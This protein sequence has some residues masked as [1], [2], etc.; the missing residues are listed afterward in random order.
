MLRSVLLF[1]FFAGTGLTECQVVPGDSLKFPWAGGLNSCQV[2]EIDLNLDGVPDLVVF[3]RFGNRILPFIYDGPPG[4]AN[5]S[6]HPEYAPLFPDLHDWAEFVDYNCD[7]KKDI[8]TYG[9]GGIR[10]FENVSDT[11]LKFRLVTS[12]VT[13]YYYTG[14]VG[15]LLTP[16]D[17]PAIADIDGDGDLDILTFFGLGSYIEYHKNLSMEKYGTCDSL[18][19]KLTDKCWG[20]IKESEGSNKLTLDIACP[21]KYDPLPSSCASGPPKHTGSTLLVTDLNGD[22]VMDLILGDVDFPDLISLIN[23]GTRDSAHMISQDTLFPSY[24]RPVDLFSFVDA[25]KVDIDHDGIDDLVVS[26]FDPNYYIAENTK[27]AWYYRNYGTNSVPDYRFISPNLFQGDMIDVGTWSLP[28]LEDLRGTGLPDLFVGNYGNYDSSWYSEGVLHSAFTSRISWYRNEGTPLSPRFH[29]V[30]DDLGNFSSLR[31]TGLYPAFGDLNGDGIPDL[32]AGNSDGTLYYFRNTG[33]AD[34]PS[35]AP[36]VAN[37]QG[38]DAG[39]FS[40]PQLFDLDRDGLPDLIIGEQNG[41]LNYYRNTGTAGNPVFTYVTDSLG[42]INVTD[43]NYSYYG[44]SAPC[45]FRTPSGET[46]L[47]VGSD[48]GTIHYYTGIDGNLGGKFH[49]SD[50]LW[51]LISQDPFTVKCGWRTAPAIAHLTDPVAFDLIAGNFSG[52][53]NYFTGAGQPKVYTS[54]E[55]PGKKD[56]EGF[57]VYPN[58]AKDHFYVESQK[59]PVPGLI[60][61]SL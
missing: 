46:R 44:F 21:Y 10:V 45:F 11:S 40:A 41:N 1:I 26:S 9:L 30:T 27:S 28:V 57:R 39:D 8:F 4:E 18:D 37:Y 48:D 54:V 17:F 2:G 31:L 43:Y 35:F 3:D 34:Q 49:E 24:N 61:V 55:E 51:S 15:I 25:C 5:Y 6:Y 53:L 33:T 50:S 36:P 58:P 52:G 20:D 7:G 14:Y 16:V 22:G 29:L 60:Q 42:R 19:Y 12:Q 23:G 38:I 32:L 13:S 59:N 56:P 47:L